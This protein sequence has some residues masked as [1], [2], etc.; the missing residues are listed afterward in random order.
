MR[1]D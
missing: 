1:M